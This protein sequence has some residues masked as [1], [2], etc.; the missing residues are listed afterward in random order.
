MVSGN[1]KAWHDYVNLLNSAC[2]CFKLHRSATDRH[3]QVGRGIA[4]GSDLT[5]PEPRVCL[6]LIRQTRG[7]NVAWIETTQIIHVNKEHMCIVTSVMFCVTSQQAFP[8]KQLVV[9]VKQCLAGV[10]RLNVGIG[11]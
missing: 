10:Q 5:R 11:Y 6:L 3:V 2:S 7:V 1:R 9:K 8:E 4:T